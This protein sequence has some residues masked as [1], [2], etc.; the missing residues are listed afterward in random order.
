[1]F[2]LE[3][4][5][6]DF[7]AE[8]NRLIDDPK[9]HHAEHAAETETEVEMEPDNYVDMIVA[10]R[11]NPEEPLEQAWVK[12]RA[13]DNEGKP[14]GK[15]HAT[16]NP[17]LDSRQYEVEY[18]NGDTEIIAANILAENILGQVDKHGFWELLMDEIVDHRQNSDAIPKEK[19]TFITTSGTTRLVHTTCGWDFYMRWKNGSHTWITLKDLK[20]SYSK[21]S[22]A[23][24]A[25]SCF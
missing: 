3:S 12:R 19:G 2:G 25:T 13:L 14:L 6:E 8:F 1:M 20:E 15:A 11:R 22:T 18:D 23:S 21:T 4:E 5:E 9:L 7:I 16:G 17:L 24:S 10:R